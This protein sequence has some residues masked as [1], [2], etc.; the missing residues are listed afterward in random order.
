MMNGSRGLLLGTAGHSFHVPTADSGLTL[1]YEAAA[2]VTFDGGVVYRQSQ[3]GASW[4]DYWTIAI[5]RAWN[6]WQWAP[7]AYDVCLSRWTED[8]RGRGSAD[9]FSAANAVW[10]GGQAEA[11]GAGRPLNGFNMLLR[12]AGGGCPADS[13]DFL[14]V[15]GGRLALRDQGSPRLTSTPTGSLMAPRAL[16]GVAE[17]TFD[18]ADTGSGVYRVRTVVDGHPRAWQSAH[19][20]G[21][22]CQDIDA[23]DGDAYEFPSSSPC[24]AEVNTA[25]ALD[26]RSVSDGSHALK[27]QAEDAAGNVTTL[28]SD[29][30]VVD[31]VPAPT[32]V[33]AP[34]VEGIARDGETLSAVAGVW[35]DHAALSPLRVDRRWQRCDGGGATSSCVDLPAGDPVLDDADVGR[36]LRVVE[37]ASNGEGSTVSASPMTDPVADVPAPANVGLPGV[38]GGTRRGG[39]LVAQAGRW[40][41]HEAA[42]DP[43][44]ARQWQ[45]CRY[46]GAECADVP[47]ATGPTYELGTADLNRRLQVVETATN[48]EGS[49][50]AVSAQTV[51]VTRED[52]TLPHD[53]NGTDDDGDGVVDEPGETPPSGGSGTGA[54][55][56]NGSNGTP[57]SNGSNGSN[58]TSQ[59]SASHVSTS[60]ILRNGENASRR[61]RL[62]VAFRDA[63]GALMTVPFGKGAAVAGRLVDES[64][65]PITGAAI[66]VTH[67]PAVRGAVATPRPGITTDADGRFATSL[68][69]RTTSGTVRFAYAYARGEQPAAVGDLD[70]RVKAAVRFNVKLRGVVAAYRGQVLSGPVPRGKLVVLQGRVKGRAWQTFASR[71]TTVGGRFSGKYRLKIRVPGRKLQF[72]A[73]VVAENGFPFL[74]NTSRAVTQ[75]GPMK[76]TAN[77]STPGRSARPGARWPLALA[78]VVLLTA[79]APAVG[80][81][82]VPAQWLRD[83]NAVGLQHAPPPPEKPVICVVDYGVNE[84][85][86]L[87]IVSRQAIDGGTLDD[88]SA[89]RAPMATAPPSRTWPPARSTA[90]RLRGLPARPHRQRQNLPAGGGEGAWA[91][92]VRGLHRCSLVNPRP[93]V[94]VLSLGGAEATSQE[95][96]ELRDAVVRSR[97]RYGM[98]V[99]AAAGN[100]GGEYRYARSAN[101]GVQRDG[102]G[103][104]GCSVRHERSR[105]EHRHGCARMHCRAEWLGRGALELGRYEF[106]GAGR[107]GSPCCTT[108]LPAG[109]LCRAG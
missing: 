106:C 36:R 71:R 6:D 28:R 75:T 47:G 4:E 9:P 34:A 2:G 104:L 33:A 15:F 70:V 87:D 26:T 57:G 89:A 72:R 32:I 96:L 20:N 3:M 24:R 63:N 76:T 45:R 14:R 5:N 51:A 46:N 22:Q 55:G 69:P 66:D 100:T 49:G 74:A 83:A 67:T 23:G 93:V 79:A 18:V 86:D 68:D 21:G 85:P 48:A 1:R 90:G 39:V 42:G 102:R 99:V 109:F 95:S 78:A 7:P 62:T 44:L 38:L 105:R 40:N 65:R 11:D 19:P 58:V 12:C 43:V 101:G 82:A 13:G 81:D 17:A 16:S 30:I 53:N 108:G 10:I 35:E 56:A 77:R 92:Y 52:G 59:T 41:D 8:C 97:E 27:L 54:S 60:T 31:N 37:T 73:R 25:V 61:A 94:S 103:S 29:E 107:C 84:T 88:V 98:S 50:R 80:D 64:G 91:S